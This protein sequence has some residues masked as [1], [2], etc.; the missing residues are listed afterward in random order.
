MSMKIQVKLRKHQVYWPLA[1]VPLLEKGFNKSA[2]LRQA[3][4]VATGLAMQCQWQNSSRPRSARAG[5]DPRFAAPDQLFGAETVGRRAAALVALPPQPT[6]LDQKSGARS[7]WAAAVD[8]A[9]PAATP[10][11]GTPC[12]GAARSGVDPPPD[13]LAFRQAR[14]LEANQSIC[15]PISIWKGSWGQTKGS[16][17]HWNQAPE[18]S[19]LMIS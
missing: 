10:S 4:P 1:T 7:R 2:P 6:A 9:A 14:K 18:A 16:S 8:G 13:G 11:E 19:K 12:Q 3:S 17:R 5:C 15:F